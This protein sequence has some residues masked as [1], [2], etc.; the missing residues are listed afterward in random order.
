M[1]PSLEGLL[2]QKET[3]LS[4]SKLLTPRIWLQLLHGY[5][6]D[7]ASS[8]VLP[9]EAVYGAGRLVD[10][11]GNLWDAEVLFVSQLEDLLLRMG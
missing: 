5:T 2:V 7:D 1:S 9:E 6:F 3:N 11:G 8:L 10:F 4:P